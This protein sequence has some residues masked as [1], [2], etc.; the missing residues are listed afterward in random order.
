M[1]GSQKVT[2]R[3]MTA[4]DLAPALYIRK[5]ALESLDRGSPPPSP[6]MPSRPRV[7]EHLLGTDPQGNFV[8]EIDGLIVGFAQALVRG[9]IW[10][11]AQLF[12]QPEVHGMGI[13]AGLLERAQQYGRDRGARV[14]SVI[15]TAQP[16]SQSL[17]MRHGMFAFAIGYRMSGDLQPLL[18]LPDADA[19]KKRIVDCSGWQDQI[20][21]MD[22]AL[23]GAERREDHAAYTAGSISGGETASFGLTRAGALAGYG[24]AIAD[25]GFI[26]PIAAYEAAD[27]LPLLKM[28]ARWLIDHEVGTG[29]IM[30]ISTNAT[31]M[32]A[33]LA[34]GWR[35]GSWTFLLAS[36]QFGNFDRY[37]PAGGVLL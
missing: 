13:G 14:F 1:T 29:N 18:E 35:I 30:A 12:V 31:L 8:A 6:W 37:H 22:R 28:G 16:V 20:A 10:F 24:Y 11:L 36:E 9:D 7:N 32:S 25:G 34:A 17:Y 5:A 3:Q 2:Y 15:S 33:L 4:A 27:Q 23:F 26:A 21:E 19:V